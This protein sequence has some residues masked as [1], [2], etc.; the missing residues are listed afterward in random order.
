MSI[1]NLIWFVLGSIDN[2][3]SNSLV[4]FFVGHIQHDCLIKY[5]IFSNFKY[6]KDKVVKLL[7][8][9]FFPSK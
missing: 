9:T 1:V 2:I 4:L 6:M 3:M 5:K 7:N 8:N